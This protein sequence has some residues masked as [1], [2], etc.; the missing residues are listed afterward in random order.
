MR[1]AATY[2]PEARGKVMAVITAR[3]DCGYRLR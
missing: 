1:K 2:T 3:V